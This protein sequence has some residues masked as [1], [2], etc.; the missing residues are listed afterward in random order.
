MVY[1]N[2][3]VAVNPSAIIVVVYSL[4]TMIFSLHVNI[5]TA[6]AVY[7]VNNNIISVVIN[8]YICT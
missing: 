1:S 5:Y 4:L 7:T 8:K 2:K 3:D 6:V